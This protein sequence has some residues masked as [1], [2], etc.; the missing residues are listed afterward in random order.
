MTA[1]RR[2]RPPRTLTPADVTARYPA[3][4]SGRLEAWEAV[5]RDGVWRYERIEVSG[6]PWSVIHIPTGIDAGWHGTLTAAREMTA[7][8][9]ALASVERQQAHQRGEHAERDPSCVAC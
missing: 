6:T 5:S 3:F 7:N 2:R 8:G 1:T 4:R 9:T